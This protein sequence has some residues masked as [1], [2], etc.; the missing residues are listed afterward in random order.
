LSNVLIWQSAYAEIIFCP[1]LWP[2]FGPATLDEAL[3]EY[4]SRQRRF[5]R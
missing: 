2:D 4:A 5:G 3:V 1:T